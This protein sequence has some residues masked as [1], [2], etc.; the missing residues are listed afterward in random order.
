MKMPLAFADP[1]ER[2]RKTYGHSL[3]HIVPFIVNAAVQRIR[4]APQGYAGI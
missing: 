2:M 4:F 3:R 1:T